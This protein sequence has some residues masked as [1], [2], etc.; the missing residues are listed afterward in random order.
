MINI[1]DRVTGGRKVT[2]WDLVGQRRSPSIG[3]NH[4]AIC[5]KRFQR[6]ADIG[7]Y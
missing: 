2:I 6:L 5:G 7:V 1:S 3:T 4:E